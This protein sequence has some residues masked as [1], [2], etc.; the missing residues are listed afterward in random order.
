MDIDEDISRSAGARWVTRSAVAAA[1][2]A[3]GL[4]TAAVVDHDEEKPLDLPTS[5]WKPGDISMGA[6]VSGTLVLDESGCVVLGDGGGR[7]THVLWPAGHSAT[8][9]HPCLPEGATIAVVNSKVTAWSDVGNRRLDV[10][11]T[12]RVVVHTHCGL[13][14][15]TIDGAL[16]KTRPRG[17]GSSPT[18]TDLTTGP[19]TRTSEDRVVLKASGLESEVVFRPAQRRRSPVC[20]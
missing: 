7:R 19:A 13:R 2:L 8:V 6:M 10:G 9:P 11:E 15:A 16:W 20:F 1:V 12:A 18:G 14:Y 4:G 3:I 17:R 5:T